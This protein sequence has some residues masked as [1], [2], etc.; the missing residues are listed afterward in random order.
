MYLKIPS[1]VDSLVG[2]TNKAKDTEWEFKKIWEWVCP[3]EPSALEGHRPG[4]QVPLSA[5][6]P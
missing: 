5:Q 2:K 4:V 3:A 6:E 1:T